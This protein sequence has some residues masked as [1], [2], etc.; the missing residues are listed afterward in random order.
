MSI[1][2]YDALNCSVKQT[3]NRIAILNYKENAGMIE[4]H[5]GIDG[6]KCLN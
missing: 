4:F 1:I 6:L 3:Q 2:I 5:P